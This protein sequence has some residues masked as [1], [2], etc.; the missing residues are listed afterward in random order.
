MVIQ[1]PSRRRG[2]HLLLS[3][4]RFPSRLKSHL[5]G[6]Y[7]RHLLQRAHLPSAAGCCTMLFAGIHRRP[8]PPFFLLFAGVPVAPVPLRGVTGVRVTVPITVPPPRWFRTLH[9]PTKQKVLKHP[10]SRKTL[11]THSVVAAPPDSTATSIITGRKY[12]EV[13]SNSPPPAPK[14]QSLSLLRGGSRL[15]APRSSQRS[16]SY[17]PS[18]HAFHP[19]RG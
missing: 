3:R 16:R 13:V 4:L 14:H 2:S 8:P 11:Q 1:I 17:S 18:Y 15:P 7:L 5:R 6:L 19:D 9:P 10:P 12:S